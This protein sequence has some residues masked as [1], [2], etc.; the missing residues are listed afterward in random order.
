M[1]SIA[2]G[3]AGASAADGGDRELIAAML[4][5]PCHAGYP[6]EVC[7]GS[8]VALQTWTATA[9]RS[10]GGKD[11]ELPDADA[12][13]EPVPTT[14]G[15]ENPSSWIA[16]GGAVEREGKCPNRNHFRC[17]GARIAAEPCESSLCRFVAVD[18]YSCVYSRSACHAAGA[19]VSRRVDSEPITRCALCSHS[20][21]S[22][23][24]EA[25]F[26]TRR[27]RA[28]EPGA[29]SRLPQQSWGSAKKPHAGLANPRRE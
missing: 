1:Y 15:A 3:G 17:R 4:S 14:G 11:P 2:P 16:W 25:G 20:E 6:S 5:S 13:I 26:S 28:L 27:I 22:L 23:S 12:E 7:T 24:H 19:S 10:R 29:T 8:R 18:V 9:W 21:G